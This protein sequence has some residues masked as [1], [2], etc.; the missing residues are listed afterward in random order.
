MKDK[1]EA[2]TRLVEENKAPTGRNRKKHADD[3]ENTK[4]RQKFQRIL[5][6]LEKMNDAYTELFPSLS[7]CILD[8]ERQRL[9]I[10][11]YSLNYR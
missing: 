5:P 6:F 3:K 4:D 10:I 1:N 9:G 8:L 11:I 7:S 2:D